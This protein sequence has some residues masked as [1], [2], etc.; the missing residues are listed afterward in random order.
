MEKKLKQ[1]A[2]TL[3]IIDK[4]RFEG[5][6]GDVSSYYKTADVF[7]STSD[8]EGYGLTLVEAASVRCPIVTTP[9]GIAQDVLRDGT[10]VLVCR[11]RSPSCFARAI[12]KILTTPEFRTEIADAAF[13]AMSEVSATESAYLEQYKHSL[14]ALLVPKQ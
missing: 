6:Q 10:S 13:F 7:V 11:D 12:I 14:E 1:L 2:K 4:V 9:V 5:W 8:F 3:R